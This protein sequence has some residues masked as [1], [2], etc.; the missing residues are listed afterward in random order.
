MSVAEVSFYG[1]AAFD[2]L[3]FLYA[4]RLH[5][6]LKGSLL[7]RAALFIGLSAV[8]IGLHHLIRV[9]STTQLGLANAEAMEVI[10]GLLLLLGVYEIHRLSRI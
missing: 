3:V 1:A 8:A 2:A 9:N 4:M 5:R 6:E 7:G 10:A